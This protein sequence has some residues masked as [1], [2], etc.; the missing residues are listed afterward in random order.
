MITASLVW[1]L[2]RARAHTLA[3]AADLSDQMMCRQ[4]RPGERHPAWLLGHLVL[5]D[6]YLL[7]LLGVEPLPED[8]P[9]LL[10]AHGPRSTPTADLDAYSS[11]SA[12]VTRL[13]QT[14]IRRTLA[15]GAMSAAD[16]GAAMPDPF[17]AK[18]QPTLEHHV[19]GLVFHEGY[20]A[21]QLSSWRR[22][23][24]LPPV[25]WQLAE[26]GADRA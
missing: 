21:G 10:S 23:H 8:F 5:A 4:H 26:P 15:I 14:G 17:L 12:L 3:L 16:L 24:G 18:S 9:A 13:E 20:H 19:Q 11:R 6:V 25:S 1:V 7:H 22:S 2:R